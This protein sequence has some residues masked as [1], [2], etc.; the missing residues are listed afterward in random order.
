MS[1][2][3]SETVES[4]EITPAISGQ[5]VFDKSDNHSEGKDGLSNKWRW[6]I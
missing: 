4:P 5:L 3:I 2:Q 1:I 6:D